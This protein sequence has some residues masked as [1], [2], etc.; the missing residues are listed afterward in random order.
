MMN[1][2]QA[3]ALGGKAVY[4]KYGTDHMRKLG[5]A[6]AAATWNRYTLQ[7]INLNDFAMVN[8]ETGQIVATINGKY[9]PKRSKDNDQ[10]KP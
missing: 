3:A 4:L 5:K 7:P 8:K 1:K 6:G 2:T 9:L 10:T